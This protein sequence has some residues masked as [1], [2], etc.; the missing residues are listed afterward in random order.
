MQTTRQTTRRY[1]DLERENPVIR[2]Q[3]EQW[4]SQRQQGGEDVNDYQAFRQHV[5]GL[6]AADPGENEFEEFRGGASGG[7][8][9]DARGDAKRQTAGSGAGSTARQ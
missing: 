3:Y 6:G 2:Q 5:R 8:S 1:E 4:R 9:G 7:A